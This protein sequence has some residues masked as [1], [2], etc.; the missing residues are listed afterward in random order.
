MRAHYKKKAEVLRLLSN[1]RLGEKLEGLNIK[2]YTK[3]MLV[4]FNKSRQVCNSV[5]VYLTLS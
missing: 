1:A 4:E 5:F 3:Q 2:S